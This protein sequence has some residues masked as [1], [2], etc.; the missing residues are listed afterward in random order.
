MTDQRQYELPLSELID[1]LT[2]LQ[3]RETLLNSAVYADDIQRLEHDIDL[4]LRQKNIVLTARSVRIVFLMGQLNTLIWLYKDRMAEVGDGGQYTRYLMLAHQVNGLKNALKN[5]LMDDVGDIPAA[6][7]TN[8]KTDGLA[9][10][11]S[12]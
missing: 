12:I 9:Y 3:L 2:I 5:R 8:I 4:V 7:R 11:V 10:H 1:K 6:H